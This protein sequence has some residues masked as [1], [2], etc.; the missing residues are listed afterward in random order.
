MSQDIVNKNQD[1]SYTNLDFSAIYTEIVDLAKQLSYR[2]DPSISD[3]SDPGVVLLKLSALIADKMNYNIDKSVLEA[4]PLSVTQ[5]GNAR[6]LYE[7]LGYYMNWY[8][9]ATVPINITWIGDAL[10][11]DVTYTIPRFT[12]VTDSENSR[13]YAIIGTIENNNLVVSDIKLPADGTT[14]QVVAM[15]GTPTTFTFLGETKITSQMIDENNRLYFETKYLSQNGIFV[16]NVGNDQDNYLQWQRVDNLYEQPYDGLRYKFGIDSSSDVAYLEFPDNYAELIGSGIEIV[17]LIIDP[18]FSNIPPKTLD[19]FLVNVIP[20]EDTNITL[21]IDNTKIEN[22]LSASGHKNVESINEA[23][24]GYKRTVGTFKTLITLRDYLNYI[25]LEG[26]EL[27]SNGFVTDR[28]NDPQVTYK[29]MSKVNGIDSLVTEVESDEIWESKPVSKNEYENSG[30]TYYLYNISDQSGGFHNCAEDTFID[31][32]QYFI[33]RTATSEHPVYESADIS[34]FATGVTYYTLNVPGGKDEFVEVTGD[35]DSKVQY[36]EKLEDAYETVPVTSS[37][38]VADTYYYYDNTFEEGALAPNGFIGPLDNYDDNPTPY[39]YKFVTTYKSVDISEFEQDVTYYTCN[40][41]SNTGFKSGWTAVTSP[42]TSG[43]QYFTKRVDESWYET[44]DVTSEQFPSLRANLYTH[45]MPTGTFTVATGAYN[46]DE[47]YFTYS[48]SVKMTP[49]SLKFYLLQDAIA[50]NS[51]NNFNQTFEMISSNDLPSINALIEDTAHIEHT[52][53]DILPFGENTYKQ[54]NDV[55]RLNKSYYKYNAAGDVYEFVSDVYYGLTHD[56]APG[57]TPHENLSAFEP[58]VDYYTFTYNDTTGK[59]TYTKVENTS[60][61]PDPSV[62]YCTYTQD[63]SY[64]KYNVQYDYY[65]KVDVSRV[66]DCAA[67]GLYELYRVD[68]E[69]S[70]V[71]EGWFEIDVE[72]L[73]THVAYFRAKYPLN[74]TITTYSVVGVNVQSDIKNNIL[75]ALYEN[76]NSSQLE[77]GDKIELDYLTEVVMAA[78]ARIKSVLF[79]NITY[80]IEAVYYNENKKQFIGTMLYPQIELPNYADEQSFVGYEICKDIIAKSI[81]AGTTTLLD[82]D[83]KFK[84]HLNQFSLYNGDDTEDNIYTITSETVIDM[85]DVGIGVDA[86]NNLVKNYT[87]KENEVINIFRPKL[88]DLNSYETGVHYEYLTF[89]DVEANQSYKL[90]KHEFMIMYTTELDANK[91][92]VGYNGKTYTNGAIIKPSFLL[93][94]QPDQDGLSEY[95][96]TQWQNDILQQDASVYNCDTV[97][98]YWISII[99]NSSAITNNLIQGS[100]SIVIQEM[101]TVTIKPEDGY[102]FYWILNEEQKAEATGKKF[103]ELFGIFDSDS[104]ED[105][106]N[107]GLINTYTLKS[108]ETLYYADKDFKNVAILHEGTTI[109]RNCGINE[110]YENIDSDELLT[111]VN[112]LDVDGPIIKDGSDNIL[113]NANGFYE[114]TSGEYVPTSDTTMQVG[115]DYYV[116]QMKS[117]SGLYE[118][119]GNTYTP[120]GSTTYDIFEPIS[121]NVDEVNAINPNAQ[122]YFEIV[123]YNDYSIEDTYNAE[124][125]DGEGFEEVAIARPRYVLSQNTNIFDSNILPLMFNELDVNNVRTYPSYINITNSNSTQYSPLVQNLYEINYDT[126][127]PDFEFYEFFETSTS[128]DPI[129]NVSITDIPVQEGWWEKDDP[130]AL[131]PTNPTTKLYSYQPKTASSCTSTTMFESL[132]DIVDTSNTEDFYY[133]FALSDTTYWRHTEADPNVL[134][135][136]SSNNI[137]KNLYNICQRV[138]TSSPTGYIN[139]SSV[140]ALWETYYSET[141]PSQFKTYTFNQDNNGSYYFVSTDMFN[142]ATISLLTSYGSAEY[143]VG[144]I[145]DNDTT[146]AGYFIDNLSLFEE[147]KGSA[148][149]NADKYSQAIYSGKYVYETISD[150]ILTTWYNGVRKLGTGYVNYFPLFLIPIYYKFRYL[151]SLKE[152]TYYQLKTYATSSFGIIDPWSCDSLSSDYIIDNPIINLYNLW[153]PVQNNCSITITENEVFPLS[154]GDT[155]SIIPKSG[156]N[157]QYMNYPVFSNTE[158]I[159]NLDNYI[160]SYITSNNTVS[161]LED[162]NIPDMYWRAYSNLLINTSDILGQTVQKNHKIKFMD[163]AGN[164]VYDIPND[165]N[166]DIFN[167]QQLIFQLKSPVDNKSGSNIQVVTYDDLGN[168]IPN[169]VYVFYKIFDTSYVSYLSTGE[170]TLMFKADNLSINIPFGLPVGKYLLPITTSKGVD[171]ECKLTASVEDETPVVTNIADYATG[172]TTFTGNRTYYLS[173][174]ID[175]RKTEEYKDIDYTLTFISTAE[176]NISLGDIF[177]YSKNPM[178][179]TED[180][181]FTEMFDKIKRLDNTNIYNYT[182]QPD[183]NDLIENP[184]LPKEFWDKNH[185]CNKYTIAQLDLSSAD[186]LNYRFITSK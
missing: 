58:D 19:R 127:D 68:S 28:S 89:S 56:Q 14:I 96:K 75:N 104:D 177:K 29:I 51:K 24:T 64:Y 146:T 61:T 90:S 86:N 55:T 59:Y 115:K 12:I 121:L 43:V 98:P 79:D 116:L 138:R 2:W 66:N 65:Y 26:Q 31:G 34:S 50:V 133:R 88:T 80:E 164:I 67:A 36:F 72:A 131:Y 33:Q 74:M 119:K 111:Y 163:N 151:V 136:G 153:Q 85:N 132:E 152:N 120:C 5:E 113:P 99:Q 54:T 128:T 167:T 7:Q 105:K 102:S 114:Y 22:T 9:S 156:I 47:H 63:K 183:V 169:A 122:E 144:T 16:R 77:F 182:F 130:E 101:N 73:L 27:C 52:Y 39:F 69:V 92:I 13:S 149:V 141:Y 41:K 186:N 176:A 32:A 126:S 91:N 100:N 161:T 1:I 40:S 160:V 48:D 30:K 112:Y 44:I 117:T 94:A 150:I 3:E 170:T 17:Y 140:D 108:G 95:F 57:M 143:Y 76:L 53:E 147:I 42:Y 155:V 106:R 62:I 154:E 18:E 20:K 82:K 134:I 71:A 158:I 4:F 129:E 162:I 135:S 157:S 103:Y 171:I 81:L 37:T 35:F 109:T 173:I 84:Y 181:I 6:Q 124:Y 8:E 110:E 178:L 38:F 165:V 46:S 23:Y 11:A 184:L 137:P 172:D 97:S 148:V 145:T 159:L 25:L 125:L 168:E 118:L 87:L 60:G 49:F 45:N 93:R 139:P 166:A 78:D 179:A 175:T 21:S 10:S 174:D 185:V 123:N 70:P 142:S 107:N 180:R 15:E 83:T